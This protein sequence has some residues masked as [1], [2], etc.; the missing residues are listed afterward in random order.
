MKKIIIG[1]CLVLVAA[2]AHAQNGLENVIVEKYYVSNA[3]DAA[4]SIGALPVGSVT[5]RVYADML[6]GYKLQALYGVGGHT[7]LLQTSTS[8]FNNEDYGSTTPDGITA[9][10]TRRNSVMLD[11]W[12]SFGSNATGKVAVLKTDDNDGALVNNTIPQILQNNDVSAGIPIS[13]ADGMINGTETSVTF[14]GINNTG[15]GDLGVF[16]ATSQVG[17]LFSTSNGSVAVLGG[18]NGPTAANRVLI[19]QFT[20][21]G[22]FGFELNIQIGTPSGGV[23]KYVARNAASGEIQFP[24]CLFNTPFISI[25]NTPTGPICAG[26]TVT[27]TATA[28]NGGTT[29]SFQWKK[30]GINVG[31]DSVNYTTVVAANDQITCVLTS[32]LACVYANPATSNIITIYAQATASNVSGCAGTTI[33]LAGAPAG[34]TYNR[35]NPYSGTSTTYTYSLTDANGC[36]SNASANITVNPLPIVTADNKGPLCPG[37]SVA[38]TGTPAGGS[39]SISTPNSGQTST[40]YNHLF[41]DAN[42]CTGQSAAATITRFPAFTISFTGLSGVYTEASAPV[43]LIG[44]PSGGTF[45]GNG[46]SGSTFTPATAGPG[47]HVITYSFTDVN[48]CSKS[49]TQTALV[50]AF[51]GPSTAVTPYVLPV[52]TGNSTTSILTANDVIGGYRLVGIPDGLGAFDNGNG[53]FSLLIN[54]EIPNTGGIIRAHGSKGAFV[55]KLIVNKASLAVVSG[56]DLMQNINLWDTTSHT[57]TTFN[58]GNPS[59]LAA[60]ARFCAADL[61]A[62]SAF[63][64]AATGLGTQ[65]R[66]FMNGEESGVE[67]RAVGH[68]ATGPNAGTSWELP[69]LGKFAWENSVASPSVSNKTIVAGMDDG[70]GGQVYFYI[71]TKT[72]TGTEI[73][74]AGLSNGK[75]FGVKV[76]GLLTEVSGSVPAPNT[77]FSLYDQGFVQNMS[78]VALNAASV[79]AGVTTFLRPEDGAWDPNNSN[80]FY[81]VTTN[82]FTLPSR[83]WKL[84]FTDIAKPEL[85][86]TITNLLDGTEGQKMLD[87]V[88]FDNYGHILLQ[89][90]VGNQ[91]HNGKIWQYTIATDNLKLIAKHDP[92]RFGDIGVAATAPFNQDEES[93]GV[94]DMQS[95]LGPGQFIIAD[96]AH[97]SITGEVYEGGQMLKMYNKDSY[98]SSLCATTATINVTACDSVFLNGNKYTVSGIYTFSLSN[99]AGCDSIVT[100]NIIIYVTNNDNNAC[101]IDA[102]DPTTGVTTY[103]PV[104]TNDNNV[105][106]IDACDSSTGTVTH[107]PISIDDNNACTTDA[108]DPTTGV[109]HTPVNI[110]DNNACTI[111]ACDITTGAITHSAVNID[112]NNACT[113]DACDITTG[114]ITHT[115]VNIDDNTVCTTDACDPVTGNITHTVLATDDGIPCT[116][117][118]CDPVNG[119]YHTAV[120]PVAGS[121][122]GPAAQCVASTTGGAVFSIT[123]VAGATYNWSVPVGL[124]IISGQGTPAITVSWSNA[125]S[126]I[127][128]QICVAVSTFCG[129]DQSCVALD[130]QMVKPVQPN[131][132]SGPGKVCPTDVVSYSVAAVTRATSYSWTLP[133]GMTIIAGANTNM[134][135]VSVNASYTGGIISVAASNAC[136]T[137]N[138][139]TKALNLNPPVTPGAI[140]GPI[141][142]VCNMSGVVYSIAAVPS[143]SSYLWTVS[144]GTIAGSNTGS[145]ITVNWGSLIT[146]SVSVVTVNGCGVSSA[147]TVAPVGKP[148]TPG[149]ISGATTV[150]AAATYPYSIATVS[151]AD[152][153]TWTAPSLSSVTAGQGTKQADIT[154]GVFSASNLTI[155]VKA[156]NVCGSSLNRALNGITI[157]YCPRLE[158]TTSASNLNVYPNPAQ[159]NVNLVFNATSAY[160]YSINIVDITGRSVVSMNDA[161]VEGINQKLIDLTSV[162]AGVY[163]V[164][165]TSENQTQQIKLVKE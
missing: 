134:I 57:Y 52:A 153:Y 84:H 138:A 121:I 11:S 155:T 126:G 32:S 67:G 5:Y 101:T 133:I 15:N 135:T 51:T 46:I 78:G 158:N 112:D 118:G 10:N 7:L 53:T 150:C 48:G 61:P 45:T 49:T 105:C 100:A 149:V 33:Q 26:N 54:H 90:D 137:G 82:A 43:A 130:I 98:T 103:T 132:I 38:L 129:N 145:S 111:D 127:T 102:C 58:S 143:A 85:G 36:V 96:Q 27:F 31:T 104:N 80:D 110:N 24:G 123:P 95:I 23:Q 70:T 139:R 113:T 1:F 119:I 28:T 77:P 88:G 75:L 163:Y 156:N 152:T 55:T 106:T 2:F 144:G 74:K 141:T 128:G 71:G 42:G 20:T 56:M 116:I 21:D 142:G 125:N 50:N 8:F 16:D 44:T 39:W 19:G 161:A 146:G 154:F 81:F 157:N 68:I 165:I 115:P 3:A 25:A 29:P 93:S 34:G 140:A 92:A 109:S 18:V 99:A 87:N 17:N 6:P 22:C 30:N 97:Y 76:N 124:I 79:A 73:E 83:L 162:A 117:D 91:A 35:A 14:V 148:G 107:T 147:R 4:G 120:P 69:Y 9:N 114:N 108:C 160:N 151:G 122:N 63:Y 136:G 64:N 131:S 40:S 12:F 159:E 94:I 59:P 41:T 62:V 72:N 66:I 65:E 13:I 47:A 164:V 37:V 89:E 86:G 60:F